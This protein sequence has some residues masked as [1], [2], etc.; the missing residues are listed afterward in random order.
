MRYV[1]L[2]A[3]D[4]LS[5]SIFKNAFMYCKRSLVGDTVSP[6]EIIYC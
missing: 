6:E 4:D 1:I 3:T 2:G 5:L